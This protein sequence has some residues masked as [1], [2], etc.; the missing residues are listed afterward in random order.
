MGGDIIICEEAAYM[1]LNVFYEVVCPL[2]EMDRTALLCISTT[3]GKFNFY[4]K[5]VD[6]KTGKKDRFGKDETVFNVLRYDLMCE[7]CAASKNPSG[8]THKLS[9]IPPWQSQK[10]HK[11]LKIMMADQQ[12]KLLQETMGVAVDP[13]EHAFDPDDVLRLSDAPAVEYRRSVS[14]IFVGIDPNGGGLSKFSLV[15]A[16]YDDGRMHICG[17][18]SADLKR[19]QQQKALLLKHLVAL[20]GTPQTQHAVLVVIPE[21]NLGLEADHIADHIAEAGL[22]NVVVMS[23][24]PGGRSGVTTD[25][26][27]KEAMMISLRDALHDN[28]VCFWD[29][30][31]SACDQSILQTTGPVPTV[32]DN[33]QELV[34]QLG[35]FSIFVDI[36]KTI[37]QKLRI[38]FSGKFQNF[39]DDSAMA[40][41]IN[42]LHHKTFWRNRARYGQ[43]Y[44][45]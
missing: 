30:C 24:M 29:K 21:S 6:M 11:K 4:T 36:P 12:E 10:K 14:H 45:K 20:R 38:T 35:R 39:Q 7:I 37:H 44:R 22:P 9:D 19:A 8:C 25:H 28:G 41:M 16:F 33:Q 42:H 23:E 1:D 5:L 27:S 32:E 31:I 17:V 43:Y 40:T 26:L 13:Q 34:A 3:L 15:S 18:D 2:L